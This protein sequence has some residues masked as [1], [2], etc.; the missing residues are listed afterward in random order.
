MALEIDCPDLIA[1]TSASSTNGGEEFCLLVADVFTFAGRSRVHACEAYLTGW[2][3]P[4]H[5]CHPHH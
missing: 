2:N 3:L 5:Q 4:E 1:R